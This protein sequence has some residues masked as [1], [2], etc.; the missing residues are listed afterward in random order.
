MCSILVKSLL[1]KE[2]Q[3]PK[4]IKISIRMNHKSSKSRSLVGPGFSRNGAVGAVWSKGAFGPSAAGPGNPAFKNLAC[5]LHGMLHTYLLLS[6]APGGFHS[7]CP[8]SRDCGGL[9][10]AWGP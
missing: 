2:E 3:I 10:K 8:L 5:R 6:S 4:N 7:S 1:I 9:L